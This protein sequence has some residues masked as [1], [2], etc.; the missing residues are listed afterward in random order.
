MD[1]GQLTGSS[2]TNFYA[3]TAVV[4]LSICKLVQQANDTDALRKSCAGATEEVNQERPSK[5]KE[6]RG[7]WTWHR[8]RPNAHTPHHSSTLQKALSSIF[9][10]HLFVSAFFT[11]EQAP[12]APSTLRHEAWNRSGDISRGDIYW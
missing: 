1:N 7:D 3:G 11:S 2:T 9:I 4:L 10:L 12:S 5:R 8:D 6:R